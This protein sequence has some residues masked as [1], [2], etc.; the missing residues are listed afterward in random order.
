M[1]C[2]TVYFNSSTLHHIM[3][4]KLLFIYLLTVSSMVFGQTATFS[5]H[6][7]LSVLRDAPIESK[8]VNNARQL[9]QA[10]L[11][12]QLPMPEGERKR[13]FA[14]E[15]QVMSPE[16]AR[17]YPGIK[18]Y[19]LFD[20]NN[21]NLQIGSLTS[22]PSGVYG[23]INTDKGDVVI[24][25]QDYKSGLNRVQY[26]KDLKNAGVNC[27]VDSELEA[28]Y[29]L[30]KKSLL[31][32]KS[33]RE[34]TTNNYSVGATLRTYKLAIAT[35]G[36][37]YAS[38][39]GTDMAVQA[40]I[41][42][43]VN[44]LKA[45]YEREAAISFSLVATKLYSNQATDP[46]DQAAGALNIQAATAFG[47]LAVAEPANFALNL[48]DIGHVIGSAVGGQASLG[49][50][51][52]SQPAASPEKAAGWSSDN[53]LTLI[54]EIGHQFSANHTFNS[55]SGPCAPQY[56]PGSAY[57]PG[58]GYT[59][60]TY[61]GFCPPDDYPGAS[62]TTRTYF[63]ANSLQQMIDYSI[64]SG[65]CS[66]NSATSNVAPVV[67]A[68]T[69][70]TIPKNT[71]F[72]LKGSGTDA[73]GDVIYYNWEQY[74]LGTT[75]GGAAA[76]AAS[77]DSPIFRSYDPS[78][79]GNIR[80]FPKLS[81]VLAGGNIASVEEALPMVG[82][83][84]NF[85]LTARD[86]KALGGGTASAS[87]VITV[88]GTAG[89][90]SVTSPN[91]NVTMAAGSSQTFTWD[92]NNTNTLS[93]NVNVYISV[94]GGYTFP[95]LVLANTPND[96]T[97]TFILPNYIAPSTVARVKVVSTNSQTAEFYDISDVDFTITSTCTTENTIICPTTS[98]SGG[99]GSAI[100]NLGL[101]YTTGFK[102]IDNTAYYPFTGATPRP[103]IV[104]TDNTFTT[105]NATNAS[106][107]AIILPFRVSKTGS[108]A[109]SPAGESPAAGPVAF[110]VFNSQTFNCNSLV[111]S[112]TYGAQIPTWDNTGTMTLNECTTYYM[113]LYAT[114]GN[115]P[116]VTIPFV[117]PGEVNSVGTNPEGF[118]YTYVA[119][120]QTTSQIA[121]VSATSNFT[122]LGAGSYTVYGI[123]Y[124]NA[125]NTGTFLNKT[126]QQVYELGNCILFSENSKILSITSS[127]CPPTKTLVSTA[128]DITSGTVI[129]KAGQELVA[130]NK[131]SGGNVTY[132]TGNSITLNPGFQVDNGAVF[133][134]QYGGC[135]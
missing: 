103:F 4:K 68:G 54:H 70:Y 78:P 15:T 81:T 56:V 124:A 5:T 93:S 99:A 23:N 100:F 19:R 63:H 80:S 134:T 69:A 28:N 127:P 52:N 118:S 98:V 27:R 41:V 18:S 79:S 6:E 51:C 20:S 72:L 123:Q 14:I 62:G 126:I 45:V 82:R 58:G 32:K 77:T 111:G 113:V 39:G 104:Y 10:D 37:Y 114:L 35:S 76:A 33:L 106:F 47:A 109:I 8:V 119:V 42:S 65:T 97:E 84:L 108:Y 9:P 95:Y 92:V 112:N 129:Q 133:K 34:S 89:P 67:N 85:R 30:K 46:F 12:I 75:T 31:I 49:T 96:G 116:N 36:E 94:D 24:A 26:A 73:N 59:Y 87:V 90:L 13:Y 21:R 64:N 11:S 40:A 16:L 50:P 130:T 43:L 135:N 128:D 71:P 3:K 125:V 44:G 17:K 131:I 122:A 74:D 66:A 2:F 61:S 83:T 115:P 1:P 57:E 107:D 25:P 121:A 86:K 7:V 53:L 101:S 105:C 29:L 22:Y 38:V 110:S 88:S 132:Q 91:T 117:G 120:N 55:I 102:F 60:L 48:Y